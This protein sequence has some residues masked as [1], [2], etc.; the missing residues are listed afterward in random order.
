MKRILFILLIVLIAP[1]Y[2]DQPATGL[3][4]NDDY[5]AICDFN[6]C[7]LQ[8]IGQTCA[9]ARD[10]FL[11]PMLTSGAGPGKESL[12]NSICFFAYCAPE[13]LYDSVMH[14]NEKLAHLD[15]AKG[16]SDAKGTHAFYTN[17]ECTIEVILDPSQSAP[18]TVKIKSDQ[19][20]TPEKTSKNPST[21]TSSNA[22]EGSTAGLDNGKV[23]SPMVS[24]GN[25][26]IG[27]GSTPIGNTKWIDYYFNGNQ[28]GIYVDVDTSSAGFTSTPIYITS[29]GGQ[30][31]HWRTVG[32][33]S[34]YEA[35]P[36][37][38]RIYLQGLDAITPQFANKNNWHIQW[39]GI[40]SA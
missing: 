10:A 27:Y 14:Q 34:I 5:R 22:N 6:G 40:E 31:H 36:T 29:L 4:N 20:K 37:S 18:N 24:S 17:S 19:C 21:L 32:A 11:I 7:N 1:V 12:I 39:I 38:F 26:K 35:T 15:S 2:A 23:T 25:A 13:M 16:Y 8:P 3:Q 9:A 28:I 33:S 30:A